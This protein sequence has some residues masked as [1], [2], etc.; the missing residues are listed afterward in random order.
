[1]RQVLAALAQ[2]GVTRAL[3][4]NGKRVNGD[5]TSPGASSGHSRRMR[6]ARSSQAR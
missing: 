6:R 2:S 1:M 5:S 3:A 4:R